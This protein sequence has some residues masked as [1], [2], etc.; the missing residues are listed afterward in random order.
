MNNLLRFDKQNFSKQGLEGIKNDFFYAVAVT[1]I[2]GNFW[3]LK[4]YAKKFSRKIRDMQL[5]RYRN[6]MKLDSEQKCFLDN[7]VD[8]LRNIQSD[9]D[10]AIRCTAQYVDF[11]LQSMKKANQHLK[12]LQDTGYGD[13]VRKA[14]WG[15]R[16]TIMPNAIEKLCTDFMRLENQLISVIKESMRPGDV[17]QCFDI[18]DA[19]NSGITAVLSAPAPKD[20]FSEMITNRHIFLCSVPAGYFVDT[21]EPAH[22][23]L[24]DFSDPEKTVKTLNNKLNMSMDKKIDFPKTKSFQIAQQMLSMN[25]DQNILD[26]YA[27]RTFIIH[28]LKDQHDDRSFTGEHVPEEVAWKLMMHLELEVEGEEGNFLHCKVVREEN[29]TL[30]KF[31]TLPGRKTGWFLVTSHATVI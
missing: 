23:I 10:N 20:I 28:F 9:L 17:L 25:K 12:H 15:L 21:M 27:G 14:L 1:H 18:F 22:K 16:D 4:D 8:G 26:T 2:K 7:I 5:A 29:P 19:K 6:E 31:L 24:Y 3:R 30:V 13:R 11:S